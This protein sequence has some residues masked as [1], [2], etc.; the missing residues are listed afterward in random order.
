MST[1]NVEAVRKESAPAGGHD[2]VSAVRLT[3]GDVRT[4]GEVIEAMF[5]DHFYTTSGTEIV[6]DGQCEFGCSGNFIRTRESQWPG[7][8]LDSLPDF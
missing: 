6:A 4:V 3:N 1:W 7:K 5:S 2:H 8:N